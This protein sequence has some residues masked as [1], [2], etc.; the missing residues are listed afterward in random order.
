[1]SALR[2]R[3]AGLCYSWRM[4]P[5]ASF[6]AQLLLSLLAVGCGGP[7]ADD[8][9][10]P[11]D[12]GAG[13]ADGWDSGASGGGGAGGGGGDDGDSPPTAA[14]LSCAA[15]APRI[16]STWDAPGSVTFE[17]VG[18]W[19]DGREEDVTAL[20]TWSVVDGPGGEVESGLYT[21]A[22]RGAGVATVQVAWEGLTATCTVETHLVAVLN[23]TGD[24]AI[25]AA[26]EAASVDTN[27]DC[28]PYVLYPLD[29]SLVPADFFSPE[30]Q[31]VPSAGQD[32]FL[33]RFE[34]AFLTLTAITRDRAW[35][36][37]GDE[38][39]AVADPGAGRLISLRV[40]GGTYDAASAAVSGPLCASPWPTSMETEFWGAP[41]AV[42]YWTPTSQGMWQVDVGAGTATPWMDVSTFGR[43]VGCH[44]VNLS[45]PAV[46]S[47]ALDGGYGPTWVAT[48]AAPS[49]PVGS[50]GGTGSFTTL[51]PTGT[52]MVRNYAGALY[53][54]DVTTGTVLAQVP[55]RGWAAHPNWS[56]DGRTLVYA[57][58]ASAMNNSDWHAIDCDLRTVEML[59]GDA[60]GVES[61]LAVAPP[62]QSFHYPTFSPDSAW[63]AFNRTTNG[64]N[65]Y[66]NVSAE[67]M[68]MAATGGTPVLLARANGLPNVEN[69]W[70]RWGPIVDNVGWIAYSSERP[71]AQRV[72]GVPQVWVTGVDL[73]LVGRGIDGSFA[74][75]W[76]PGQSTATGNHTPAFVRR[77]LDTE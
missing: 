45:N 15:T 65:S 76:L 27:A 41:G 63:V 32:L 73:D 54:D 28:A 64:S 50:G 20:A 42:F 2:R 48:D 61:V 33:I 18:A 37:S 21:A 49:T 22:P 34:T 47:V 9:G 51:D 36:P 35:T 25:A 39:W 17:A 19:S 6:S 5:T 43:C 12:S 59:S 23:L 58:C 66:A 40:L 52:R 8:K 74:P 7:P 13:G 30:V 56:P 16:D 57:S 1:M 68:M 11:A 60:F 3:A 14:V 55:T 46:F 71:Y 10:G 72:S 77:Q 69:S 26:A 24:P 75:V 62:G 70:P 29:Q 38:W 67:L 53:L 31:W 44:T 4:R